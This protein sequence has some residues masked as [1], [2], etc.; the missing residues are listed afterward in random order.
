M[1]TRNVQDLTGQLTA[2][3]GTD[4]GAVL[5]L[6]NLHGDV[7]VQ[8]SPDGS[9]DLAV[10]H[11]DEYGNVVDATGS[12][13]YGWLGGAQR[14][15][16]GL[17]DLTLMG[18][19]LYDAT[20]GRFLQPD[21]VLEGSPNAY[22]YPVDPITMDDLTGMSWRKKWTAYFSRSEGNTIGVL[23]YVS[24]KISQGISKILRRLPHIAAR[25]A[26]YVLW[27]LSYLMKKVGKQF[28]KA[29]NKRGSHGV[30]FTFGIWKSSHFWVPDRPI[31]RVNPRY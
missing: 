22:G 23:L 15:A 10:Y 7:S 21:P 6:T 30:K 11:Y 5:L 4:G 12:T 26:G 18:V 1:L 27:A 13:D 20:T 16:D 28:I 29:A 24:G 8:M 25:A 9:Q 31:Y 17:S 14:E 3:T 2:A 19:R